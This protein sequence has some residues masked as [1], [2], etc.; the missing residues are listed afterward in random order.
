M[1]WIKENKFLATLSGG[2]LL[3]AA[4][5][6]FVGLQG[7]SKYS[8][9]KESFDTAATEASEF[10]GQ[11]LYPVPENRDGK[12]K[13]LENYKQA[14]GAVQA[15]FEPFR[16]KEIKDISPQQFTDRLLAANTEVRSAFE[17]AGTKLPDPFF[18]GYERYKTS[19]AS[20]TTTGVLDYQLS[21]VKNLMLA[22]AKAGASEV[23]N[24]Y[25]P[26]LPEEE[27][28][29][30]TPATGEVA[31]RY[32]LEITFTGS[33]KSVR[34]FFSSISKAQNEF[35][36]IRSLRITNDK[37]DPPRTSDVKFEKAEAPA[38]SSATGDTGGF[39]FPGQDVKPA[40]E[41]AAKPMADSSQILSQILGKEK[42]QV[43][44][45]LDLLQFLP[46]KKLP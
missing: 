3:G 9:L 37:K 46:A 1:S 12:S 33:E 28:L 45:R 23:K 19:L 15:A 21:S 35:V 40:A 38:S 43:F 25:R 13:A 2:T 44:L 14:V 10:E 20:G 24:L 5:L 7:N 36:V 11:S 42:V 6:A 26:N 22:L 4:L 27:N 31:R 18:L 30:Y 16:P 39:V 17:E 41:T 29:V 8:K 32:P 34:Q